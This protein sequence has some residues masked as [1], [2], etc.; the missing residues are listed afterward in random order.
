MRMRF[1]AHLAYLQHKIPVPR[2][3]VALVPPHFQ[4]YSHRLECQVLSHL[5]ITTHFY[6]HAKAI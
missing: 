5:H 3:L 1:Q 4:R 2:L 6:Y